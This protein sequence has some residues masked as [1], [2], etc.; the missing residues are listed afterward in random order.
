MSWSFNSFLDYKGR[1]ED[2]AQLILAPDSWA[3]LQNMPRLIGKTIGHA[4]TKARNPNAETFQATA[5]YVLG[6]AMRENTGVIADQLAILA[7]QH[8][9]E[10]LAAKQEIKVP[11]ERSTILTARVMRQ[12]HMFFRVNNADGWKVAAIY[13]PHVRIATEPDTSALHHSQFSAL[14]VQG[15]MTLQINGVRSSHALFLNRGLAFFGT[16]MVI[17]ARDY[18]REY[19]IYL[20]RLT[21]TVHVG[22]EIKGGL[23]DVHQRLMT[24]DKL[25]P[26]PVRRVLGG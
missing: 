17:G 18:G 26:V 1:D 15:K 13:K 10:H 4:R 6:S 16:Q 3:A 20:A 23:L 19:M 24:L 11:K 5:A 2:M 14:G 22:N 21:P 25:T 12:V 8:W 9:F 7:R